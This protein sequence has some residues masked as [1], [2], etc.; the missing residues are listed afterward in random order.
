MCSGPPVVGRFKATVVVVVLA[1]ASVLN[2]S[3]VPP[4][5]RTQT[6]C[7][8]LWPIKEECGNG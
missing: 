3:A 5:T 7:A 4:T 6:R 2:P 1:D 8:L